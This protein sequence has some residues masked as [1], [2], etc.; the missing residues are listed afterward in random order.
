MKHRAISRYKY[1]KHRGKKISQREIDRR[2]AQ[3]FGFKLGL[4]TEGSVPN[5]DKKDVL[6]DDGIRGATVETKTLQ[7]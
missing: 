3:S 7:L 1:G 6:L 5:N 2:I 4:P